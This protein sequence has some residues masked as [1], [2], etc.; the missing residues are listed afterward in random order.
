[1]VTF[2]RSERGGCTMFRSLW[3]RVPAGVRRPLSK[4]L[5][6]P[7]RRIRVKLLTG[8]SRGRRKL[9]SDYASNNHWRDPESVSGPGS[10]LAQTGVLRSELP[11]LLRRHHIASLLDVPC[12]DGHWFQHVDLQLSNYVGIDI[13]PELVRHRQESAQPGQQF[14]CADVVSDPLPR[15]DA[16]LCRDLLVHFSARQAQEAL[17]NMRASG[18]TFLLA[19]HFPG[20]DNRDI[21]TGDWRPINLEAA[22][23]GFPAPL[24]T[25][26]ETDTEAPYSD[27]TLSLWRFDDLPL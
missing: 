9:F 26:A 21:A 23:Y 22:P 8:S 25:I 12:G 16:I 15:A 1:M 24:D 6:Q 13:V 27:K 2:V 20:R 14:I 11:G 3:R 4:W 18:A 7:V 19:T 17:R 10:N 5:F